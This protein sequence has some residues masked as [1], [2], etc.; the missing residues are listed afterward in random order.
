MSRELIIMQNGIPLLSPNASNKIAILEKQMKEIKKAHDELKKQILN[1][2]EIK[3]LISIETDEIKITY[4]NSTDRETF[5]VKRFRQDY[6]DIYDAYIKM[7]KVKPSI[8]ITVKEK[9]DG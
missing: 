8:R 6:T 7:Q 9:K 1:E 5:D 2:M 4:V 3:K